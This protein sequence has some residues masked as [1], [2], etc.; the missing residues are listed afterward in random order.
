[1]Q[2]CKDFYKTV[3]EK[4]KAISR[5]TILAAFITQSVRNWKSEC[6][7]IQ[8]SFTVP[9]C[10]MSLFLFTTSTNFTAIC[11]CFYFD[12]MYIFL[13]RY[14]TLCTLHFATIYVCFYHVW[15]L[16]FHFYAIQP[17]HFLG[18][19]AQTSWWALKVCIK[20]T[21]AFTLQMLLHF[22]AQQLPIM[23]M[24][25]PLHCLFLARGN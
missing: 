11:A 23:W 9:Q 10:I 20:V 15:A 2:E 17:H 19:S 24:D 13:P 6:I 5:S 8:S 12:S 1:M 7:I 22:S 25:G 16:P 4:N 3:E 14:I 18:W 21:W